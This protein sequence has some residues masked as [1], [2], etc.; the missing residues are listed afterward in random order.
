[1]SEEMKIDPA[2]AQALISQIGL[3]K[4]RIAAVAN[5]RNVSSPRHQALDNSPQP[6]VSLKYMVFTNNRLISFPDPS[7]SSLQTEAHQ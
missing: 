2:R 7:G 3:V 6:W 4:D 1:M 5:G